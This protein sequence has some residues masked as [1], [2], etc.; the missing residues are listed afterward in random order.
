VTVTGVE[1]VEPDL[2]AAFL[3]LTGSSLRD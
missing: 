3:H 2:E 1:V